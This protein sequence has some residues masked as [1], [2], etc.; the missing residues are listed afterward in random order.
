MTKN[1]LSI[2]SLLSGISLFN[3]TLVG[4]A[5][6]QTYEESSYEESSYEE[7]S[8][9]ESSYEESSSGE[10]CGG[11]W[12]QA[13]LTNYE[14]YPEEG[15]DECTLYNGC[16]WAG[17]FY[18]LTGQQSANWVA[19]NN[20]AAVHIKDWSWLGHKRLKLRQGGNRISA[21]AYDACSDSDCDGCC[22]N[23]LAGDGYLIDL[24]KHTME[25]FGSGQGIVE[26]QVCD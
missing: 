19:S 16:T 3:V 13:R 10:D 8:Y 5:S 26:F 12:Y 9:E 17:T 24:E 15:S 14:S 25:R 4:F 23:N 18:G 2:V 7:S 6:A 21:I 20:I 1:I 11:A 22:T